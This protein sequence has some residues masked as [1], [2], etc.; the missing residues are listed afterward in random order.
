MMEVAEKY[1]GL[2]AA[3]VAERRER[4][5]RNVLAEDGSD[6]PLKK[7][8]KFFSEPVFLLLIGAACLYF[9]LGE[10]RDGVVMLVFVVF[11]GAINIYQEWKTDRT[12]EA[13]KSLSSPKVTAVRGGEVV[14]L[15]SEELVPGDI[16]LVAEGERIAADG[17]V[18][19]ADGFGADES[20]LTGESDLVWKVC[21]PAGD[22]GRGWRT[23]RCY[24][25]TNAVAG[26]AVIRVTDTGPRTEYGKI[27]A[28]VA[29]APDRPTPLEKQTRRLVRDCSAFSLLMLAFVVAATYYRG[30]GIIEAALSGVTIAM[31]T[32]PEEFPVVLTVFLALGAWRLAKRNS[33]IRRIPSV[34]TLGA[35]TVLCVDK[36]GTLTENRMT[37]KKFAPLCGASIKKLTEVAVL[38]SESNPYDPMERAMLDEAGKNMVDVKRLQGQRLLHE[39]PFSSESR[40]MCHVW[41]YKGKIMAAAKG[42][43]ESIFKLCGLTEAEREKALLKQRQL[44]EAGCR[45][46][47]VA[48]NDDMRDIPQEMAGCALNL[49]GLAAFIDPPRENVAE[50]IKAC[51][52]AGVRVVMITGD[53]S[54]TA[55]RIAHDVGLG[56]GESEHV[57][58]TGDELEKMAAGELAGKL[59]DVTIFSRILPREK[60]RIVKAL[61][62]RGEVVAMTG[63]GVNDAPALKYADIGI[64]MGGRGTEVAREAA[65]MVL[66]DDDFSTIVSTIRDGRRIYDNIRKAMEY[67]LVIHIPIALSALA[68]PLLALPVLLAPIHVVLLELIIDPTCSIIFERQP[69]ER[70]I[71][72]RQPRPVDAPIVTRGLL[73]KALAQG[74]AIFAAAFG[75]YYLTLPHGGPEHARTFFLTVLVLS[76]LFLV[77]VNRSDKDFAF[78]AGCAAIDKTAWF[79]N[80]GVLLCLIVMSTLPQAAAATKLQPLSPVDFTLALLTAAGATFWWEAVKWAGRKNR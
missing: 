74:L 72:E 80:I 71:M 75:S 48:Y 6:G 60:M 47:A 24:A 28:D 7:A 22:A 44:A 39:Y 50:A 58:I 3:E 23:D 63:D 66:L 21:A 62:A 46:L 5:G 49:A 25:G 17:E 40:M 57:M 20:T 32:I 11:M 34:E 35:V 77:Y 12:L 4:Y 69:E 13:L 51:G 19:E 16:I 8:L 55:H 18:L 61:R 38:A 70:D 78:A 9:F 29:Q 68:A 41:S 43:P 37:L 79:V 27:G 45:V 76:N 26:R 30:S 2:T 42:S 52:S 67:I 54:L 33:L 64:A 36:T 59:K 65:D 14:T 15:P 56:C 10:P 1:R 31:A 53:N 73:G